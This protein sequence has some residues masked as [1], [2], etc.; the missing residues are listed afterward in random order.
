MQ[1]QDLTKKL[2]V[3]TTSKSRTKQDLIDAVCEAVNGRF[4]RME[5]LFSLLTQDWSS[6]QGQ[7]EEHR[8]RFQK[9]EERFGGRLGTWIQHTPRVEAL[10]TQVNEVQ[11][12]LASESGAW[13]TAIEDLALKIE[14]SNTAKP[15]P[16]SNLR[17]RSTPTD[18]KM[19]DSARTA[20]WKQFEEGWQA[21]GAGKLSFAGDVAR[22]P[23]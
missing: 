17:M 13:R 23:G 21:G 22:H 9:L 10:G 6:L 3:E 16:V 19:Q 5:N 18:G 12:E 8:K 11:Y 14:V 15:T 1:C 2:D 7:F 20:L 4:N